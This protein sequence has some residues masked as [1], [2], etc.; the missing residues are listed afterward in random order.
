MHNEEDVSSVEGKHFLENF[1]KC[2]NAD[3]KDFMRRVNLRTDVNFAKSWPFM[4]G[5]I[6]YFKNSSKISVTFM[7]Q[8]A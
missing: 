4:K 3:R 1:Q 5:H 2:L 8:H 7:S 6:P